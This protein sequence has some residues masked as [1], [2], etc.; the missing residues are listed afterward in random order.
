MR[1]S[2]R[3]INRLRLGPIIGHTDATSTRIWA[4]VFDDPGL[5]TLRIQGMGS[6]PFVSTETSALEFR[7]AIA[8]ANGL[9]PDRIYSYQ[10]F[11]RGRFIPRSRGRFRTMPDPSSMSDILFSAISC[12]SLKVDGEWER[13]AAFVENSQ[14]R[15]LIMMG[16]Q[17]YI[18]DDPPDVFDEHFDSRPSV[19]RQALAEKY[20]LNW[21]REPVRRVLA[22]VPTYMIWDDHEI[23]DGWGSFAPDSPTLAAKFPGSQEIFDRFNAYFEDTRDV[24][25][26]F[27]G[28]R[29]PLPVPTQPPALPNYV[30]GP[31]ASG[32]R[33]AMPYA[34]RCGR[35][36]VLVLDSRGERDVF[37]KEYPV[38]GREQWGFIDH[39][40]ENLPA[41][42]EAL[43]LV[44]P[45]PIASMD[46][47]GQAQKVFGDRS[48]DVERFKRGDL[49]GLVEFKEKGEIEDAVL[50]ALN[51]RISRLTGQQLNLGGFKRGA[52]D[53]AR[54]QWSHHLSR[55]EQEDLIRKAGTARLSNRASGAPRGLIFLSGDIHVGGI[56]DITCSKPRFEAES[57]ISSGISKDSG[58]KLVL[59]VFLDEDFQVASGIRSKLRHVVNA[60]NFGIVHMIPTGAGAQ[61][62]SAVAHRGN[63]FAVGVDLTE[64][65]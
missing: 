37:R 6:F 50:T 58:S 8:M 62:K 42:V 5:Y 55:P 39:V 36:V 59:G 21:Q 48:D 56:Y 26:H 31:P 45:T 18:D 3:S 20:R 32:Q 10:V 61:I 43:A 28:C 4:Q 12:N 24:Y 11:R 25:W 44:T 16:D 65:L 54:D 57:L 17:V 9:R 49:E 22:N 40:F 38:L 53:E 46:P 15:F 60:F 51:P 7:T 30:S 19:R 34:F 47:E 2:R 64:L 27:Q 14:P 63:S 33:R 1:T 41:D 35:M 23:R 13:L 29:N 52:I